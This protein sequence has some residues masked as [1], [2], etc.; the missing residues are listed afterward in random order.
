MSNE[1]EL[2]GVIII[3]TVIIGAIMYCIYRIKQA[4]K[5]TVT[6]VKEN[7]EVVKTAAKSA[8]YVLPFLV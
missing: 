3:G 6:Y 1:W 8:T 7:P 5:A 4:G 2:A